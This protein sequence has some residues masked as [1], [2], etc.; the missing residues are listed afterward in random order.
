MKKRPFCFVTQEARLCSR[1]SVNQNTISFHDDFSNIQSVDCCPAKLNLLLT[2]DKPGIPI[3]HPFNILS[4]AHYKVHCIQ[5]RETVYTVYL[6]VGI[7]I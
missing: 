7:N 2:V 4:F 3:Q 6:C 1:Y 5:K